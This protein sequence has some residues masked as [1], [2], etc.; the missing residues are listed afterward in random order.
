MIGSAAIFQR[1]SGEKFVMALDNKTV[2]HIAHLARIKVGEGEL[3]QLAGELN[4][5]IGWIEQLGE[6]DTEGVAPMT[7][8]VDVTLPWRA[9]KVTDGAYPDKVLANAP[10]PDRGFYTV[11]KVV[12]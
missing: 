7:S 5:I 4:N 10:D 6:V 1:I 3:E 8:V 9:D 11:P 2:A 12:E